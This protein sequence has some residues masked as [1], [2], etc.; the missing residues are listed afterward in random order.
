MPAYR[1]Y[2]IDGSGHFS[3]AEWIEAADDAQAIKKARSRAHPGGCELW[4][5]SR[6]LGRIQPPEQGR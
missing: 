1:L 5:G 4:Q 2:H 3:T 6:L